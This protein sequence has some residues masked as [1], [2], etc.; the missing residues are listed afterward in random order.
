[1]DTPQNEPQHVGYGSVMAG[2]PYLSNNLYDALDAAIANVRSA[3]PSSGTPEDSTTWPNDEQD[4]L[5][6]L[7]GHH[8]TVEA[9]RQ[10][11]DTTDVG[12]SKGDCLACGEPRP[13][14]TIRDLAR[15]YSVEGESRLSTGK[16]ETMGSEAMWADKVGPCACGLPGRQHHLLV[17]RSGEQPEVWIRSK[18][19]C[20]PTRPGPHYRLR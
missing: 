4:L 11:H 9:H 6:E 15:R 2:A 16:V 12:T 20:A 7:I 10:K 14:T 19:E 5:A 18:F 8:K 17:S 1:M 13:C 3:L